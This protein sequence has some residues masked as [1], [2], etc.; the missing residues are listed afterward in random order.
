M[1]LLHTMTIPFLDAITGARLQPLRAY[2]LVG[3]LAVGLLLNVLLD[4]QLGWKGAVIASLASQSAL[5]VFASLGAP[6]LAK[7]LASRSPGIRS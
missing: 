1:V 4:G 6:R 3:A 7:L 2:G 5:L